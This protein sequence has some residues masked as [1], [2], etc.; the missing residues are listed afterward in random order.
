MKKIIVVLVLLALSF[1]IY[2]QG[3]PEAAAGAQTSGSEQKVVTI[4]FWDEN[5][6]PNRTPYYEELIKEFEL[7][8]PNIKIKYVGLPW[9]DAKSKYDIAIQ[10]KTT[11]DVGGVGELWLA[12]FIIKDALLPIDEYFNAWDKKDDAIEGYL[13]SIR[14]ASPDKQL[15]ALMNTANIP[16]YWYRPDV[17]KQFGL[18]VPKTW[19]ELFTAIVKTT[20]IANNRY[21]FSIRGGAGGTNLLEQMLYSYSG[22]TEM[23][24]EKGN[25]TINAPKNIELVERLAAIYNKYT[26]ESDITNG[27]K[28]MVAAFDTKV[29]NM[30]VH[31][32]GSNGEHTK[33]LGPNNFAA[34]TNLESVIG[35]KVVVTN[36]SICYSIFKTSKHPKEAFTFMSWLCERDQCLFWNEAIGQLPTIKSALDS[37]YVRN[38]QHMR[39]AAETTADPT[40]S[41]VSAPIHIPGYADLLNNDSARQWQ[42]VL[43]GNRTAK[44]FLDNWA[45][46]MTQ[47]K[48]EYDTYINRK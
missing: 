9:S 34:L 1:G 44:S 2:A 46:S 45:N 22:V 20:D 32:L 18:D 14:N 17:L 21:G 30:I 28:E 11:P 31:N 39:A 6:G 15:Y 4:T 37:D 27:Y 10:S 13:N 48:K 5:A 43:L 47:L 26:P 19:E 36:G 40:V 33:T 16:V 23:F 42:E 12:D 25:S 35:N 24:D 41:I 8:H 38:A 29:A 3:K 7:L